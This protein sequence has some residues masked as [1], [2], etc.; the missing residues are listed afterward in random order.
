MFLAAIKIKHI[1]TE[2]KLHF[3]APGGLVGTWIAGLLGFLGCVLTFIIGFFPPAGINV[4]SAS[5]Y[6]MV[7][8]IGILVMLL[9]V[10]FLYIYKQLRQPAN[11]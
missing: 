6:H 1:P 2:E 4:G 11:P 10:V 8:T 3:Q 9:P 5:H 7:F